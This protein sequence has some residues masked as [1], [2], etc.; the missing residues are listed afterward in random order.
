MH[1]ADDVVTARVTAVVPLV[2]RGLVRAATVA[3]FTVVPAHMTAAV[4]LRGDQSEIGSDRSGRS[5]IDVIIEPGSIVMTVRHPPT[6]STLL[7]LHGLLAALL[8][9]SDAA[10]DSLIDLA[11]RRSDGG[12]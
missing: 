1:P 11:I 3:G 7:R 10:G 8:D 12:Q 9:S 5:E 4:T 6:L 2:R